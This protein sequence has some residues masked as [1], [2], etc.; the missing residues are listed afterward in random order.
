MDD[1]IEIN[2]GGEVR[3]LGT[4]MPKPGAPETLS[5]VFGD[6][7]DAVMILRQNWKPVSLRHFFPRI[8]NQ[9]GY[10]MCNCSATGNVAEGCRR[11]A[12]GIADVDLSAGDLYHRISGGSDNGSL[13]EDALKELMVGGIAPVTEVPYLDWQRSHQTPSRP[14]YRITEAYWCPTFDHIASALQQGFLVDLGVWWWDRDP[15]DA[16]GWIGVHGS[17]RKGGHAM[18]QCA[19]DFDNGRWGTG[20]VQSWG[21]NWAP[22]FGNIFTIPEQRVQEG[23]QVFQAWACRGV[24]Q[25]SGTIPAPKE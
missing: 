9:N 3:R 14:K 24:V 16:K 17:G 21:Q 6:V 11:M 12:G 19:L 25:E 8:K 5:Q 15:L 1:L 13:P 4:L 18:A 2:E 22:Q 10:G 20:S 23:C 7:G